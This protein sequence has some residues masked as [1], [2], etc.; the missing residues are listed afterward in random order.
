MQLP[1]FPEVFAGGDC[2]VQDRSLPATDQVAYQQGA[3]IAH[4]LKAIALG[5]DLK[6]ATVNL[7][8]TLLK[9]G[10][11]D[12]AANIF[13]LLEIDGEIGHLIRQGTYLE[14][15]PTPIHN[16]KATSEWIKEEIFD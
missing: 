12:A 11:E 9:L 1:D 4:N 10:L 7:R 8:G 6:P 13:D 2:A 15:L 5:N 16:F 3:A 14:M